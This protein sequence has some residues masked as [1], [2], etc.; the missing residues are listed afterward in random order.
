M[1][2]LGSMLKEEI[3]RLSRKEL[4]KHVEPLKKAVAMFRRDNAA[5]KRQAADLA[6]QVARLARHG[7][8]AAPV[9]KPSEDDGEVG[10]QR[11]TAG[12]LRTQR[13]RMGLSA[14]ELAKLVGVSA[15]SIYNW[16]TEKATPRR[17]QFA[18]LVAMRG[19]G[20]REARAKL[21][22]VAPP[23]ENR[24]RRSKKA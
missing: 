8:K 21:E 1:P 18:T 19:W 15:Q 4:R 13:A 14:P 12:G 2:N 9:V 7:G 10:K 16:E 6:R 20:K 24:K 22:Q 11:F 3:S 5:L 23:S 17:A